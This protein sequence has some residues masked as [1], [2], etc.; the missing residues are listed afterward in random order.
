MRAIAQAMNIE[1][2]CA[3]VTALMQIEPAAARTAAT[4]T[5]G[6]PGL[7]TKMTPDGAVEYYDFAGVGAFVLLAVAFV[8]VYRTQRA[9][10]RSH[11][12]RR[13]R[14]VEAHIEQ[15]ARGK[16]LSEEER[17]QLSLDMLNAAAQ[18]DRFAHANRAPRQEAPASVATPEG[19]ERMQKSLDALGRE[20]QRV[21]EERERK[22]VWRGGKGAVLFSHNDA[23]ERKADARGSL[24]ALQRQ[25]KSMQ[26]EFPGTKWLDDMTKAH[27]HLQDHAEQ[28]QTEAVASTAGAPQSD[29]GGVAV[30]SVPQP[31][32]SKGGDGAASRL[33]DGKGSATAVRKNAAVPRDPYVRAENEDDDGY[34]PYSDR[35]PDPEPLFERDPWR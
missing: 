32:A 21:L 27:L 30:A 22:R 29:A 23:Q 7:T 4:R 16:E 15:K 26:Q 8:A 34:D 1:A 24:E 3:P 12:K 13:R 28:L 10:F 20:T 9:R 14:I 33:G 25:T 17:L 2:E 35:R 18:G 5:Q 19:V 11:A 31:V 6:G